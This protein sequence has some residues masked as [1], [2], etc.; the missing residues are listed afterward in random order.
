MA[1]DFDVWVDFEDF[2]SMVRVYYRGVSRLL[3]RKYG[4]QSEIGGYLQVRICE[5]SL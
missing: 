1:E 4:A 3:E 5:T 2:L